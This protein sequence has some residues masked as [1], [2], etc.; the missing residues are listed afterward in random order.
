MYQISLQAKIMQTS[1]PV[2]E[3]DVTKSQNVFLLVQT[4]IFLT[5]KIFYVH[6]NLYKTMKES[7]GA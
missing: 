3:C 7:D 6:R 5:C 1:D 4:M 2:M